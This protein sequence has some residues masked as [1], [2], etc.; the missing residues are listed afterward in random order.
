MPIFPIDCTPCYEQAV[1]CGAKVFEVG[2]GFAVV[3]VRVG[4]GPG[5]VGL[6]C[7]QEPVGSAADKLFDFGVLRLE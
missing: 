2:E 1:E 4:H 5:A 6:L 3:G 7:A